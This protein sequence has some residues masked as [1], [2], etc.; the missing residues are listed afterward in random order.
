[1]RATRI[2][3]DRGSPTTR[4]LT[5]RGSPCAGGKFASYNWLMIDPTSLAAYLR[6]DQL[7]RWRRG[8]AVPIEDYLEQHPELRNSPEAILD[9]IWNEMALRQERG[10]KPESADYLPRFGHLRP[11]IESL[12]ETPRTQID[13]HGGSP[14]IDDTGSPQAVGAPEVVM[15]KMPAVPGYE[16]LRELGRGGMGVVYLARHS[17]LKREVALKMLLTGLP[18]ES[19]LRIRF[20]TEAEAV[21]R[22]QHPHIV[23]I[24]EVG[25]HDGRPFLALEYVEGGSLQQLSANKPQPEQRA[26]R[27]VETL[28]RALHYTH[29]HDI[30]HRDLKPNNI[31]LTADGTPKITDF[32]LA[33]LLDQEGGP[34][35]HEAVIGTPN[36]MP[37]EQAGQPGKVGAPADIYSLGAILYEL[38]TG[39]APFQGTSMLDTLEQVRSREPVPPR[40]LGGAIS[41]DLETICLKCLE[42]EPARR[43]ASAAALADDLHRFTEGEPI[44]A[45]PVSAGQRLWRSMRR[46]PALFACCLA[47]AACV[48]LLLT[49]W[50]Y[51]QV[52]GQLAVHRAEDRFRQFLQRR[53][54]AHFYGLLAAD[55]GAL[56]LGA[57]PSVNARA[58]ES[59]AAAALELAGVDVAAGSGGNRRAF[60]PCAA[61]RNRG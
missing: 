5:D 31:L 57:E 23:Q 47:A 41:I 26:A 10:E 61:R 7:A 30:L 21:A 49:S 16:I 29:Q 36:Y 4:V 19:T 45:R 11:Q 25:E 53:N 6:E 50:A 12:F 32:G 44:S 20:R 60:S 27:L 9:L 34:T 17:A 46:R 43:Y 14:V 48:S 28:A 15:P 18:A 37:P 51:F 24:H 40:Q 52:I 13:Q 33:K 1:M 39:R 38:L 59:A 2:L 55:Q 56:F 42:K 54:D 8:E 35:R 3:T 22:L 58:A